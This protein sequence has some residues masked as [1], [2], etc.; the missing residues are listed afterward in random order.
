MTGKVLLH[1]NSVLTQQC[2][3]RFLF[4]VSAI[5]RPLYCLAG[6]PTE[7][8]FQHRGLESQRCENEAPKPESGHR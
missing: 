2:A 5:F 3:E 4:R 6:L 1:S 8:K 7:L